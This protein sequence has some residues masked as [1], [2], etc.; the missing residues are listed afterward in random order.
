H[1]EA[2]SINPNCT[3]AA[4]CDCFRPRYEN[5]IGVVKKIGNYD[6]KG[7]QDF[8][9]VLDRKNIDATLCPT[10]DHWHPLMVIK[11]CEAGKDVYVEKPCRPTVAEGRAMVE[12][13]RR[14]GRIVQLG[15]QQRSMTIFQ[16]AMKLIH[17]GQLGQITSATCW[18]GTNG[19]SGSEHPQPPPQGLDWN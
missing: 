17:S 13:A 9:Q 7:Y 8:R 5:A 10:C 4:V 19:W 1:I 15:T 14:Y 3:V 6:T 2:L 18:I 12:A 11:G 16:D